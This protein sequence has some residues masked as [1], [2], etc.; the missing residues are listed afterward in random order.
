[1]EKIPLDIHQIEASIVKGAKYLLQSVNSDNGIKFEDEGSTRSGIWV[2]AE[3]LEF[4]LT[5]RTLSIVSFSQVQL[6]LEYILTQQRTDGSWSILSQSREKKDESSTIST[7]HC[8][9]V[10]KLSIADGF[11]K[12]EVKAKIIK[13]IKSGE[14]WLRSCCIDKTS[15]AFWGTKKIKS[16]DPNIDERSRIEFIFDSYYASMGL[17]NPRNYPENSQR[18]ESIRR[19]AGNFFR[20]QAEWFVK[21]YL[22]ILSKNEF[23][24]LSNVTSTFCRL[25]NVSE[26]FEFEI[27]DNSTKEG[28]I[29]IITKCN[30]P[31]TTTKVIVDTN[32]VKEQGLT[33]TNNTPFDLG[34]ALLNMRS[35][36]NTLRIIIQT[37]IEKQDSINGFWLL[38]FS[39]AYKIKTWTTSEALLVLDKAFHNY[40]IM[41]LEEQK[42]LNYAYCEDL[43]IKFDKQ[44]VII[45]LKEIALT[46]E[47]KR[48]RIILLISVVLS[49]ILA[50]GVCVGV[51]Y[52]ISL[53]ENKDKPI[54][55]IWGYIFFP[56]LFLGFAQIVSFFVELYNRRKN[57]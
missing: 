49:L 54:T 26:Y 33:Y 22:N 7:G 52:Y 53:P 4:F 14:D 11:L 35:D 34:M 17:S 30:T 23:E 29:K 39:N 56:A 36:I 9:Y 38:N 8:I 50:I 6:L 13:A 18:D 16:C 45:D 47:T 48:L 15:Y 43:Q 37:Y 27:F 21:H 12:E 51:A 44:K 20:I 40:K 19:K 31:F 25:I 5:T 2:T 42:K 46:K 57:D 41:E 28:I 3:A 32:T 1:M 55:G 24:D 10:L